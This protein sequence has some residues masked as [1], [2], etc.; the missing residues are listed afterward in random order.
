[1]QALQR[2]PV[3]VPRSQEAGA[4][5]DDDPGDRRSA[6]QLLLRPLTLCYS[7]DS[8]LITMTEIGAIS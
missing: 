7:K 8:V 3:R 6:N 1:V 5:S 4:D 2:R